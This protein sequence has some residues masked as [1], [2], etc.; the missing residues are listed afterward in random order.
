MEYQD[1][2]VVYLNLMKATNV[3]FHHC[4]GHNVVAKPMY[5]AKMV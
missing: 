5:Q 4:G 3:A 2:K 1:G